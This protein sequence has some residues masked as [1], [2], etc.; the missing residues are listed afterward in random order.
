M[1]VYSM[2]GK[3]IRAVEYPLVLN[4]VRLSLTTP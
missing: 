4:K 3:Y 2:T 1:V